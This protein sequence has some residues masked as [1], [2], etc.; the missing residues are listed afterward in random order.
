MACTARQLAERPVN[1]WMKNV[2]SRTIR[3]LDQLDILRL[4]TTMS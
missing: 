3:W 1:F 4:A 2:R